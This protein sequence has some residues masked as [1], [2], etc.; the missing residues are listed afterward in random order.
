[1]VKDNEMKLSTIL[2]ITGAC[3]FTGPL[4]SFTGLHPIAA[5]MLLAAAPIIILMGVA[6]D[7]ETP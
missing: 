5:V 1:M 2:Y 7:M 4:I 6:S 3:C